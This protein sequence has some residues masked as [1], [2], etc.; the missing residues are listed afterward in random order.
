MLRL[1]ELI[2][3]LLQKHECVIVPDF[4]GFILNPDAARYDQLQHKFYPPSKKVSFNKNLIKNDGLLAQAV[5]S[6]NAVSYTEALGFIQEAKQ[7]W[8]ETL[9]KEGSLHLAGLGVF[10]LSQVGIISFEPNTQESYGADAFGLEPFHALP[11]AAT[12]V[13]QPV[14][15]PKEPEVASISTSPV[16]EETTS[17][18]PKRS[19]LGYA[20]AGAVVLPIL[21]YAAWLASST[22]VFN[23]QQQFHY[24]DLNPFSE[25][26]CEVY[27]PNSSS[28]EFIAIEEAIPFS[29]PKLEDMQS[30]T[31]EIKLIEEEEGAVI[32]NLLDE[33][34]SVPTEREE[35]EEAP[36]KEAIYTQQYHIIAGCF[37]VEANA[38]KLVAELKSKG[39]S[40]AKI[41]DKDG[42]LF[43]VTAGGFNNLNNANIALRDFKVTENSNAW[44]T[45]K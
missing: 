40:S 2:K 45:K 25:K 18:K 26:V 5:S 27:V 31:A 42:R 37:G 7:K 36:V 30:P 22:T 28:F 32:V 43:R 6:K 35:K 15:S 14:S 9:E 34:E 17:S 44:V 11:L 29:L 13:S 1:H 39:F 38:T 12:V 3:E 10:Q 16:H 33:A 8:Q 24:S 4:G 23:S 19:W 20:A 41:L 21:S